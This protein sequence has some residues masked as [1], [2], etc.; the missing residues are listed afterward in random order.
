MLVLL[1]QYT[2]CISDVAAL[3]LEIVILV[4][5]WLIARV[6]QLVP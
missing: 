4:L 5:G 6:E 1:N 3:E 2:A